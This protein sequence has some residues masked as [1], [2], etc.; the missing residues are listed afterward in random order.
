MLLQSED[1]AHKFYHL[2]KRV[3]LKTDIYN[4]NTSHL[5]NQLIFSGGLCM[6]QEFPSTQKI[7]LSRYKI[8]APILGIFNQNDSYFLR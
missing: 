3:S 2:V 1:D 6:I 7:A 4:C 5:K 8:Y